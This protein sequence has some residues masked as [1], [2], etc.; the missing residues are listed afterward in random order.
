MSSVLS[1][2]RFVWVLQVCMPQALFLFLFFSYISIPNRTPHD[3]HELCPSAHMA[4][5]PEFY[6]P[7]KNRLLRETFVFFDIR[8]L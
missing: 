7:K 2:T 3:R 4:V 1:A 6:P 8:F 5:T